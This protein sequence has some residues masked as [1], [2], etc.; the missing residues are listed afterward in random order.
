MRKVPDLRRLA[1]L[2]PFSGPRL[3]GSRSS[4]VVELERINDG[5]ASGW[6][7]RFHGVSRRWFWA[8]SRLR[9]LVQAAHACGMSGARFA[10]W[11]MRDG[12]NR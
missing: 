8:P 9:A 6:R 2:R 4:A 12:S 11:L 1:E 5:P 10:P 7:W 3:F